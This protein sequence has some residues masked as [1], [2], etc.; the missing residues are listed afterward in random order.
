MRLFSSMSSQMN[1]QHVLGFK[2]FLLSS[3]I[4]PL[5]NEVLLVGS[6]M[7]IVE[8]LQSHQ[9]QVSWIPFK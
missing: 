8:M 5:A 4:L 6:D 1:D 7:V 2:G 3:A 9:D